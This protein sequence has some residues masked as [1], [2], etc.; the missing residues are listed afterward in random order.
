VGIDVDGCTAV[1]LIVGS[2]RIIG[3]AATRAAA[4]AAVA[5]AAAANRAI[6]G[7]GSSRS[8]SAAATRHLAGR[9]LFRT[10][11]SHAQ[12]AQHESQQQSRKVPWKSSV[13][14]SA[15]SRRSE[16]LRTV[17]TT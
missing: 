1:R 5:S 9:G 12:A 15:G 3:A 13:R 16:T 7:G 8:R 11:A 17:E 14:R 2:G 10:G 4:F 6:A